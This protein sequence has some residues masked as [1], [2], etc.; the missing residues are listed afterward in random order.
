MPVYVHDLRHGFFV[1]QTPRY[2]KYPAREDTL[3]L[4]QMSSSIETLPTEV[5]SLVLDCFEEEVSHSSELV[6]LVTVSSQS[7]LASVVCT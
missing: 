1:I 5:L 6:T 3:E 4:L 7:S 2:L